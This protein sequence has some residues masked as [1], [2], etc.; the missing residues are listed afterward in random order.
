MFTCNGLRFV[1]FNSRR[2][3]HQSKFGGFFVFF[4]RIGLF[5]GSSVWIVCLIDFC[6]AIL[7]LADVLHHGLNLLGLHLESTKEHIHSVH[8]FVSCFHHFR[9]DVPPFW[10]KS[11][12]HRKQFNQVDWFFFVFLW[13]FVVHI[14]IGSVCLFPA[15]SVKIC[16]F[17][18]QEVGNFVRYSVYHWRHL[19]LF[20]R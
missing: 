17:F 3:V 20:I 19:S 15:E 7:V 16:G 18:V 13:C 11:T 10:I 1:V 9:L 2:F 12:E 4:F 5:T 6:W 8:H 14:E